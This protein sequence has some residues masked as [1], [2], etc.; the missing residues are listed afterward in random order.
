MEQVAH[1]TAVPIHLE[2]TAE[3]SA[4]RAASGPS[5]D[6]WPSLL[7]TVALSSIAIGIT[8]D[9]SWH[10]TV[11]RDTFWTPAHMAIYFGG[12]LAGCVG[13]WLAFKHT[14]RAGPA[15]RDSSVSVFGARAPLGAWVAIWGALAMLTSAPFDDWWHNAYGLD[16]KIVSPPHAVLGLGM[17]GISVGALLLVLSRQNRLQ[18]HSSSSSSTS[19]DHNP[20]ST[21]GSGMFIYAG[22]VFV[23]MGSVF[24]LEYIFPNMQHAALFYHVCALMYPARLVALSCAGRISWP[25]TRVAAV[26]MVFMCVMDWILMQFP[27]QPKLAPIFNPVTHMVPLPFPLLLIFPALAIDLILRKAGESCT[28]RGELAADSLSPSDGERAGVRG[29]RGV[30]RRIALAIILGT[31]FFAILIVVQWYF[32]KFMLSPYARNWF[33]MSDRVFG[34]NFPKG[35][36]QTQFWRLDPSKPN[37]DPITLLSVLVTLAFASAS[38]WVGL[39]FGRWMRKVRR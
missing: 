38:S 26:Y 23:L 4:A 27:A 21:R 37:A 12:V 14:F 3:G 16:V 1:S 33:F 39:F 11:G 6:F 34:Y 19:S 18:D 2:P 17:F 28:T 7:M 31:V 15:E 36:W 29:V 5:T 8:W 10:E 9:I 24:L 22:G 35:E 25:A 30:L 32:S 20:P 13:G